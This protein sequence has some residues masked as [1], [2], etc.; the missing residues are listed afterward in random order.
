MKILVTGAKGLLGEKLA[1]LLDATP[2]IDLVATARS[3]LSFPLKKGT[4]I[5]LDITN[6][7][8]VSKVIEKSRPD[9]VINTA[10]MTQVDQCETE[11]ARCWLSNATA[12]EYLAAAC[13]KTQARLI[14]ISTDFIF[15]GTQKLLKEDAQPAPVNYYGESKLAGEEALKKSGA[16]WAIA[17]TVL[18]YGMATDPG[19]S[20]IVLWVKK[21]LEEGKSINVV[22][23]QWR[24]P[25]L[26]EDLAMGCYLMAAKEVRGIYHISGEELMTPYDLAIQTARFF[27]LDQSL[28]QPTDSTRFKQP[29]LR[30]LKTGFDISK[31]KSELGYS[32]HSFHEGLSLMA[33][34]C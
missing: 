12:V 13:R 21:N 7:L 5:Q 34:K 31:A 23:D 10:A 26:A 11:R 33:G 25:T 1:M 14:H 4:F 20:N 6:P 9:V 28:I 8:E 2:G 3:P 24:T 16:D 19:R 17:R 18:V 27:D 32:P 22:N 15:D 29:A 30:P